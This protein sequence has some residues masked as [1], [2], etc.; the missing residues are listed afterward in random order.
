[1]VCDVLLKGNIWDKN[2]VLC[3]RNNEKMFQEMNSQESAQ[4][5]KNFNLPGVNFLQNTIRRIK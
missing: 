4:V 5:R 3:K 1:M 2:F